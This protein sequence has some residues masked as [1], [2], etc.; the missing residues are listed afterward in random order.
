MNWVLVSLLSIPGLMMGLLSTRGH[1]RGIEPY[2]WV[3]LAVFATLVITRTAEQRFFLHGLS[4][5]IAW[6]V[7]NGLVASALFSI[8]LQHN[9][10]TMQRIAAGSTA[11]SPRLMFVLSAPMIGLVTGLVLGGLC[12]AAG[13]VIRP[14][15]PLVG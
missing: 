5:G 7:L 4:V 2:L 9:P 13:H 6:G 12:W 15:P 3:V 10:E 1:T 8:Y 14:A 11:L